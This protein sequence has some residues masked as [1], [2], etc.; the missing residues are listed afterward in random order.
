LGGNA[1]AN[2]R[3]EDSF[4]GGMVGSAS[5]KG[6]P[7]GGRFKRERRLQES[8][9]DKRVPDINSR[10]WGKTYWGLKKEGGGRLNAALGER[11]AS[12][13]KIQVT[14]KRFLLQKQ[15]KSPLRREA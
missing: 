15:R 14:E 11:R 2:P 6:A 9:A 7:W 13:K 1:P 3:K 10:A 4:F 12:R 8:I 5:Q